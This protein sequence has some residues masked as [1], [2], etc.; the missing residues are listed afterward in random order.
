MIHHAT[1]FDGGLFIFFKKSHF[2][3]GAEPFAVV[4]LCGKGERK[5]REERI[6]RQIV[7][8]DREK[9]ALLIERYKNELHRIVYA[10]LRHPKDAE[11]VLRSC[12]FFSPF[13]TIG[14]MD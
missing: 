7:N 1:R 10:V 13:R 12:K 14:E 6:I 3:R 8:G 2:A 11:D 4:Y 9:Y 5:I